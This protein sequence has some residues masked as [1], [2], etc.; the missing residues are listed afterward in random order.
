[1]NYAIFPIPHF[2]FK[3][4]ELVSNE[5]ELAKIAKENLM[6]LVLNKVI[7]IHC[8]G[9]DKYGRLLVTPS[10]YKHGNI[11]VWMIKNKYAKAYDGGTKTSWKK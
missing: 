5:K 1:M 3:N 11:C 10:T 4:V 9:W 7:T 2:R 8:G 6:K